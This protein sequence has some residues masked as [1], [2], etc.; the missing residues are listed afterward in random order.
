MAYAHVLGACAAARDWNLAFFDQQS[1]VSRSTIHDFQ[2][3]TLLE[4]QPRVDV[5]APWC[6]AAQGI[7]D[8]IIPDSP[9]KI[10]P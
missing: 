8:T 6:S 9:R 7:S 10:L 2:L 4:K 1:I 3:P 5:F